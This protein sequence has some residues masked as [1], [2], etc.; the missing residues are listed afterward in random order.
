M[1]LW[2]RRVIGIVGLLALIVPLAIRD[3]QTGGGLPN[4]II[5]LLAMC[6][7]LCLVGFFLYLIISPFR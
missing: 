7:F 6:G 5:G 3:A 1:R 2:V 4:G